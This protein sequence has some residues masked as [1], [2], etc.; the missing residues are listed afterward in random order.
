MRVKGGVDGGKLFTG[1]VVGFVDANTFAR[2]RGGSSWIVA[3][4]PINKTKLLIFCQHYATFNISFC[5]IQ[6]I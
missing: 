5:K 2:G 1:F 3:N 6:A 4:F